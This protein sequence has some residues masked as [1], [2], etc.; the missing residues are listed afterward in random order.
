MLRS[1]RE[2]VA[3]V[4]V[5][6]DDDARFFRPFMIAPPDCRI[7]P[8]QGKPN[9]LGA[10]D[11]LVR[12]Q[13]AGVLPICDADHDRHLRLERRDIIYVDHNDLE[14]MIINS[15]AFTRALPELMPDRFQHADQARVSDFRNHLLQIAGMVGKI[16]L[17]ARERGYR[18][19]FAD[20]RIEDHL[21]K[22]GIDLPS[23]IRA[24]LSASPESKVTFSELA[25]LVSDAPQ[26]R[27]LHTYAKGHDACTLLAV[28]TS[29]PS[30][31]SRATIEMVLRVAFD[32][33]C[34]QRSDLFRQIL[35]WEGRTCYEV[36]DSATVIGVQQLPG[37]G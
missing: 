16:R 4:L 31:H 7:I 33:T 25:C 35:D 36:L 11:I 30:E 8:C 24:L 27:S 5:E 20:I 23:Y 1:A 19:V 18:L 22:N 32:T 26:D 2:G 21:G 28:F 15:D 3:I 34:F 12:D 17:Y 9:V 14:M 29:P 13:I 10:F 37:Q 6:G